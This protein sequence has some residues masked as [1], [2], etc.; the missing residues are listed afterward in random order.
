SHRQ[1]RLKSLLHQWHPAVHP[2]CAGHSRDL[3]SRQRSAYQL[4]PEF[5]G[6]RAQWNFTDRGYMDSN[7]W[8]IRTEIELSVSCKHLSRTAHSRTITPGQLDPIQLIVRL[9]RHVTVNWIR[10]WTLRLCACSLSPCQVVTRKTKEVVSTV[11]TND[12]VFYEYP[13]DC[14]TSLFLLIMNKHNRRGRKIGAPL[15]PRLKHV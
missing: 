5:R 1:T 6:A 15:Q 14:L 8:L 7:N 11:H 3:G 2:H 10:N 13:A 12:T 9:L 4:I